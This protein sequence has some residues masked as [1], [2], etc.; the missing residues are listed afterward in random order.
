MPDEP[1]L[2]Q[3]DLNEPAQCEPVRLFMDGV[4]Q[5]RVPPGAWNWEYY[6]EPANAVITVTR[7]DNR[8]TGTQTFI[9]VYLRIGGETTLTVKSENSYTDPVH[10]GSPTFKNLYAFGLQ[11]C[12]ERGI[13]LCW[14]FT[15]L[16]KVWREKLGFHVYEDWVSETWLHLNP[17]PLTHYTKRHGRL[18]GIA[19]KLL[20]T[21]KSVKSKSALR[22]SSPPAPGSH[23]WKAM[24]INFEG[25]NVLLDKLMPPADGHVRLD[26]T[27]KYFDWRI[28]QNPTLTYRHEF[29]YDADG[30]LLGY[31]IYAL[32]NGVARLSELIYDTEQTRV[33]VFE[34]FTAR[35]LADN[36]TAIGYFA[37]RHHHVCK[38]VIELLERFG[39]A[40][41]ANKDMHFVLRIESNRYHQTL[42]NKEA[43][44]FNALWTEGYKM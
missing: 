23:V 7:L 21:Y 22:S 1:K 42:D 14:G 10:R 29:L 43:W 13:E 34:R 2:T 8:V 37:N 27:E 25:L 20:H 9:P 18:K 38:A 24:P 31:Y 3:I 35:V 4:L 26:M 30:R 5:H 40:T 11:R 32:V 6:F 17:Q 28:T 36:A 39:A 33:Y 44:Y 19:A 16:A 41:V 12:A 15:A